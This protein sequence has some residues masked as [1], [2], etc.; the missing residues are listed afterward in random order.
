MFL[1]CLYLLKAPILKGFKTSN[2]SKPCILKG[3]QESCVLKTLRVIDVLIPIQYRINTKTGI[4][5]VLALNPLK[6]RD[7]ERF[8]SDKLVLSIF[9]HNF[10]FL[11]LT[12]LLFPTPRSPLIGP[13]L[14]LLLKFFLR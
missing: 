4:Y 12:Y 3:L 6:F 10:H 11:I 9:C 2:V 5:L 14:I 7:S 8:C 1:F 13:P